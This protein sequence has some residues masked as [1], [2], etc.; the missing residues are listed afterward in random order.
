MSELDALVAKVPGI[1]D[2][3]RDRRDSIR[4]WLAHLYP[5]AAGKFEGLQPDRLGERLI[6]R[7]SLDHTRTCIIDTL[8]T[9]IDTAEAV[10]LLT[11]CTR[12]AAHPTFGNHAADALTSYCTRHADTLLAPA[13]E[14]ATRVEKPLPLIRAVEQ[15]ASNSNMNTEQLVRISSLLPDSSQVWASTS[16]AFA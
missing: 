2:Q 6:G 13:I 15:H 3:P 5:S 12:A 14:T 7:L 16:A 11:V 10:T 9:T 8:A 4:S 1:A